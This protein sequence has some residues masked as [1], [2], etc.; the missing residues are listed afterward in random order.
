M[1]GSSRKQTFS[2]KSERAYWALRKAIVTGEF[3]DW[4][5]LDEVELM[6]RFDVGRTPIREAIRQLANEEFVV[7]HRRRTPHVRTTSAEDLAPLFEARHI[8]EIPA[9]R[10]ATERATTADLALMEHIVDEIDIAIAED[11][12]YDVAELDYDFHMAVAK[13]SHNRFLVESIN[14]LNYGSLRLWHR[15]Y[16]RLGTKR[17]NDHHH[18]Q[19]EAIRSREVELAVSIAQTHIQFS[20]ERQ[21][22]LFGLVTDLSEQNGIAT[23]PARQSRTEQD[24]ARSRA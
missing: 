23:R 5:P 6:A 10:L 24:D 4:A 13:A 19:L 17:V 11:R 9:A 22:R 18:E 20:H 1:T 15:S 12:L 2:T 21:L 8:F 3:A 7:W 16:Q 14:Y